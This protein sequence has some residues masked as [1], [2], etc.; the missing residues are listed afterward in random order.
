[1]PSKCIYGDRV[2]S[3]PFQSYNRGA[4]PFYRAFYL[5]DKEEY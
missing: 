1:M 4:M 5:K 3:Q 2:R